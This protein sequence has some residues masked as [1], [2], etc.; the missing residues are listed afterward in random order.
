MDTI[1]IVYIVII[2]AVVVA[3]IAV[4]CYLLSKKGRNWTLRN[5]YRRKYLEYKAKQDAESGCEAMGDDELSK[6]I[7]EHDLDSID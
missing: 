7:R 4:S 1:L 5:E 3:G 2:T 6:F